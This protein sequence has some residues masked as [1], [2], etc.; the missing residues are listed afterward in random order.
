MVGKVPGQVAGGADVPEGEQAADLPGILCK[1]AQRIAG[2]HVERRRHDG[3]EQCVDGLIVCELRAVF[4][5]NHLQVAVCGQQGQRKVAIDV[6]IHARHR[7]LDA[8]NAGAVAR[9]KQRLPCRWRV[10][11]DK[12]VGNRT[13]I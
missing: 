5:R 7:K 13:E 9:L 2:Q 3:I 6:R 8:V 1:H 11:S 4:G 12:V 10:A